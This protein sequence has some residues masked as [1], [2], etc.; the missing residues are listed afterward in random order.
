MQSSLIVL[1]DSA[2]FSQLILRKIIKTVATRCQISRLK[3]TKIQFRLGL[4]S[5]PRWGSLQRSP[6]PLAGFKGPTSKGRAGERMRGDGRGGRGRDGRAGEGTGGEGRWGRGVLWS[7]KILKIDPVCFYWSVIVNV[8]LSCTVSE[9]KRDIG[10]KITINLILLTF[11]APLA[12]EIPRQ[13]WLPDR[14]NNLTICLAVSTEYWRVKDRQTDGQIS[15]D[16]HS[17]RYA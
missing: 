7:Q 1:P 4:R 10:K 9:I 14:E 15:C 11:D 3:C 12:K 5:R 8:A 13:A 6:D 2:V 17:P 16:M